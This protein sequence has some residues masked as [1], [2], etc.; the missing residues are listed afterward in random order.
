VEG[1][2]EVENIVKK[3]MELYMNRKITERESVGYK[4]AE[5]AEMMGVGAKTVIRRIK[6]GKLKVKLLGDGYYQISDAELSR[7]GYVPV[8]HELKKGLKGVYD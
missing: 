4:P 6:A 8:T 5:I 3:E 7:H 2:K 1:L